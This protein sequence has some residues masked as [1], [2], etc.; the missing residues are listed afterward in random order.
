ML[1]GL[2]ACLLAG[3]FACLQAVFELIQSQFSEFTH[4]LDV[5]IKKASGYLSD[6]HLCLFPSNL[7]KNQGIM[8]TNALLLNRQTCIVGM[9]E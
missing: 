6:N 4:G 8:R 5:E 2:F 7:G 1:A 9:I 3:L